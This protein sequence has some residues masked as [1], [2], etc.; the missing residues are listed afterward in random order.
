MQSITISNR[1]GE[2]NDIQEPAVHESTQKTFASTGAYIKPKQ[3]CQ[4]LSH[5]IERVRNE[6]FQQARQMRAEYEAELQALR[7]EFYA[8]QSER[9]RSVKPSHVRNHANADVVH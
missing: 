2:E 6:S 7:S 5:E 1:D 4:I 3:L 8:C 9:E